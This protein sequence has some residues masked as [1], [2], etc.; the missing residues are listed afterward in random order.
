M[1]N[2]KKITGDRNK[3]AKGKAIVEEAIDEFVS[4]RELVA[5]S[6][7][8]FNDRFIPI[9]M[10]LNKIR[11]AE[12]DHLVKR[13]RTTRSALACELLEEM[14]PLVLQRVYMEKTPEEFGQLQTEILREFEKKRK[15]S[16][17][18][19]DKK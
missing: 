8:D 4:Q 14:I 2:E 1:R 18:E 5:D 11:V 19:K 3:D 17:R 16:K 9:T 12:L 13:W 10:R 15:T 6:L 7:D